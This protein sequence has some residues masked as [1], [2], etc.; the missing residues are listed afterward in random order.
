MVCFASSYGITTWLHTNHHDTCE[1]GSAYVATCERIHSVSWWLQLATQYNE[2]SNP[3]KPIHIDRNSISESNTPTRTSI[4]A[5]LL[6]PLASKLWPEDAPPSARSEIQLAP[7]TVSY[8][9]QSRMPSQPACSD[10]TPATV[11]VPACA[12]LTPNILAQHT[13]NTSV[14]GEPKKQAGSVA[15]VH[16]YSTPDNIDGLEFLE[17][18]ER[19]QNH[20]ELLRQSAFRT[21]SNQ[22]KS[23]DSLAKKNAPLTDLPFKFDDLIGQASQH[24]TKLEALKA[25][26]AMCDTSMELQPILDLTNTD[27]MNFH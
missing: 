10:Y 4:S 25:S 23:R 27:V 1:W 16:I 3:P 13:L 12:H 15:P 8:H 18:K 26:F 22:S 11:E 2:T 19:V 21:G 20:V 24:L 5:D 7:S 14:P 6:R 9:P 17:Q